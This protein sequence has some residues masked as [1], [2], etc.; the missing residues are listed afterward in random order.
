M[1]SYLVPIEWIF[2]RILITLVPRPDQ[3][4]RLPL[5]VCWFLIELQILR[6]SSFDLD[7]RMRSFAGGAEEIAI[8]TVPTALRTP[9]KLLCDIQMKWQGNMAKNGYASLPGNLDCL[10]SR[11]E[12]NR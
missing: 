12:R 4:R 5:T 11:P 10:T 2:A 7:N 1:E 9:L 6:R 8:N 3:S